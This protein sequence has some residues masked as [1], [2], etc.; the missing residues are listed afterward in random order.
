[1]WTRFNFT[2]LQE[3]YDLG[4]CQNFVFAQCLLNEL[5]DFGQILQIYNVNFCNF[6]TVMVLSIV[7]I[8]FQLNTL[9]TYLSNLIKF[10]ICIDLNQI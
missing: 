6:T 10:C 5:M 1:M 7:K 3:S 8:L 2:N 9:R 4:Y